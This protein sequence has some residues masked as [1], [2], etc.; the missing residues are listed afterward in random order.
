MKYL[1]RSWFLSMHSNFLHRSCFVNFQQSQIDEILVRKTPWILR[2]IIL[3][4]WREF[5]KINDEIVEPSKI[6]VLPKWIKKR[7]ERIAQTYQWQAHGS[8][9]YTW[10][11]YRRFFDKI[12]RKEKKSF[13]DLFLKMYTA[14][15]MLIL[16]LKQIFTIKAEKSLTY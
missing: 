9:M 8:V 4:K 6:Y 16:C 5:E 1:L 2:S 15:I 11:R 7:T 14:F 13:Y 3:L 12:K 10:I